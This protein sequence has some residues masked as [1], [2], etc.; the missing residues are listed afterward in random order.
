MND[1][2]YAYPTDEKI[3]ETNM[4]QFWH[5]YEEK[6]GEKYAL[7][8]LNFEKALYCDYVDIYCSEEDFCHEPDDGFYEKMVTGELFEKILKTLNK[9]GK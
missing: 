3:I 4:I 8:L 2:K 1:L 9:G 5:K 6:F 7:G